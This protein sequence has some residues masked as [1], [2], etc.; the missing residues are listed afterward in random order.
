[1]NL[2]KWL[3]SNLNSNKTSNHSK[4]SKHSKSSLNKL[5]SHKQTQLHQHMLMI[6]KFQIGENVLLLTE[7]TMAHNT[8]KLSNQYKPKLL[9]DLQ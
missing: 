2:N 5:N 8:I 3:T 6:V 7:V 9:K 4:P 1:M